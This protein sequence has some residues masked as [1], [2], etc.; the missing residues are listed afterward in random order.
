MD[1]YGGN[2]K[3]KIGRSH[4][5][6]H[7]TCQV[8]VQNGYMHHLKMM[9]LPSHKFIW[10]RQNLYFRTFEHLNWTRM[11]QLEGYV[12]KYKVNKIQ[13]LFFFF[14]SLD[15]KESKNKLTKIFLGKSKRPA[16]NCVYKSTSV[17]LRIDFSMW[18]SKPC[19]WPCITK[20]DVTGI[21]HI[22]IN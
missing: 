17:L 5:R 21:H 10:I 11:T 19:A 2:I 12:I 13:R 15:L 7:Q 22:L 1:S 3:K 8:D 20:I 14:N 18:W 16:Q 6:T 9:H 4:H